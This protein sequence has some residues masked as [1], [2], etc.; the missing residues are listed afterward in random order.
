MNA[1]VDSCA[2]GT[3]DGSARSTALSVPERRSECSPPPLSL[4]TLLA[5][6]FAAPVS[7]NPPCP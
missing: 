5:I 7:C 1:G 4:R 3:V 6:E 2:G